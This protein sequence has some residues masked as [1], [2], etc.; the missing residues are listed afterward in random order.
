MY[1]YKVVARCKTKKGGYIY[2]MLR[3]DEN[4]DR[5]LVNN[6]YIANR[7]TDVPTLNVGDVVKGTMFYVTNGGLDRLLIKTTKGEN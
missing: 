6:C 1:N 5:C 4:D 7:F 3:V 2:S